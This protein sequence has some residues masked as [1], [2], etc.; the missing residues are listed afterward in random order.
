MQPL[1]APPVPARTAVPAGAVVLRDVGDLHDAD[2]DQLLAERLAESA[3]A[4]RAAV[5][6]ARLVQQIGRPDALLAHRLD[7]A[8]HR[9]AG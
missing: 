7:A 2:L 3:D 9:L 6:A 5:T 1:V 4:L 8:A